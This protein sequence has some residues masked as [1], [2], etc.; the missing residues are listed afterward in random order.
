MARAVTLSTSNFGFPP[1]LRTALKYQQN[2]SLPVTSGAGTAQTYRINSVFDPDF[3]GAGAQP[4]YYD[5]FAALYGQYR[6][7]HLAYRVSII[8]TTLTIGDDRRFYMFAWAI[9]PAQNISNP[10]EFTLAGA[11]N[12]LREYPNPRMLNWGT[13]TGDASAKGR[14]V[15]MRKYAVFEPAGVTPT[16]ARIDPDFSGSTGA[17]P[18]FSPLLVIGTGSTIG[19]TASATLN[20]SVELTYTV[21]FSQLKY[22]IQSL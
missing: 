13:F 22:A 3:T 5:T 7:T 10:P 1:R 21:E 8:D 15:L 9:N 14:R 17:N 20:V 16:R 4:R 11:Y 12:N 2:R 6:V 19:G 18:A